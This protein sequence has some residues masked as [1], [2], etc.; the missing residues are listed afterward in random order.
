MGHNKEKWIIGH[1]SEEELRVI[2][3]AADGWLT[4]NQEYLD[5]D[6]V[7]ALENALSGLSAFLNGAIDRDGNEIQYF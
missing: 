5:E 7:A 6:E 4:T 2:Y 3:A 1:T